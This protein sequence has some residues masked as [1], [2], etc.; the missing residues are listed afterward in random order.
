[1]PRSTDVARHV[2][3]AEF[4]LL[5]LAWG[6]AF[7]LISV[8]L[9]DFTPFQVV[10]CRLVLGAAALV[11][12]AL[13]RRQPVVVAPHLL[14]HIGVLAMLMCVIPFSLYAHA[15]LRVP[16][17]MAIIL[18]ATTPLV[19]TVFVY[20][21]KGGADGARP[22]FPALA[23]S[24]CGVVVIAAPWRLNT[25][26]QDWSAVAQCLAAVCCY[27]GGFT[28]LH[29]CTALRG[30]DIGSISTS[31]VVAGAAV[32][33]LFTP[34]V[35][36][37]FPQAGTA[38]W[39]SVVILG[40]VG[41]GFAYLWN[42][43]LILAWGAARASSVT[44]VMPCVGMVFGSLFLAETITW[45]GIAGTALVTLGWLMSRPARGQAVL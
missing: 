27:A 37:S 16:S 12:Y 13:V 32:M 18:N 24:F 29:W 15:E 5:S 33:L 45:N 38:A 3:A 2:L 7:A 22:K 31:L 14:G 36:R 23:T 28:Y 6:T 17:H 1:M 20:A 4:L 39:A 9:A 40:T 21:T 43:R 34:L 10:W 44:Y 35:A 25:S 26:F 42:T 41:T 11:S 8:A 30:A 19:T